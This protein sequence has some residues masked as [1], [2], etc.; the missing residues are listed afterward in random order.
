MWGLVFTLT[1]VRVAR[2]FGTVLYPTLARSS[3]GC[4]DSLFGAAKKTCDFKLFSFWIG[5]QWIKSSWIYYLEDV[6][7]RAPSCQS[8]RDWIIELALEWINEDISAYFIDNWPWKTCRYNYCL[9]QKKIYSLTKAAVPQHVGFIATVIASS[10][11]ST[12][13]ARAAQCHDPTDRD[14]SLS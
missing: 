13:W 11:S 1:F 3:V 7:F 2:G 4:P 10:A 12:R 5:N 6:F 14:M 9:L 8:S